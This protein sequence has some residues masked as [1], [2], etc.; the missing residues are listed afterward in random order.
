MLLDYKNGSTPE[1]T[2]FVSHVI[3]AATLA[4]IARNL[5]QPSERIVSHFRAR[6][7]FY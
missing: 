2:H 1:N 6:S 3:M 7:Q 4:H 5:Q